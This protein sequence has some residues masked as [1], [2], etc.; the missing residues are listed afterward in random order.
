MPSPT[1][2]KFSNGYG[3]IQLQNEQFT[4]KILDKRSVQSPTPNSCVKGPGIPVCQILTTLKK[5]RENI[6]E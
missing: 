3:M 5:A 2:Q 4:N 1:S 6:C